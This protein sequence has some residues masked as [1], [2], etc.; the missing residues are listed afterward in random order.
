LGVQTLDDAEALLDFA[1]AKK[2]R[3][4]VVVGGGYIGLEMAEA[5]VQ[6][7]AAV[8]LVE[9]AA[10]VM[11]TLD[12]DLGALVTAALRRHG[13]DVRLASEVTAFEPGKVVTADGELDADLVVLGIGVRPNSGLAEKAGLELGVAGA[14]RVDRR[15]RTSAEAVWAAGDC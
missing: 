15:Q 13:I 6:R 2:C 9:R 3:K 1:Q 7:G 8:T 11:S 14:I 12:P 4:I 5:F 10:E